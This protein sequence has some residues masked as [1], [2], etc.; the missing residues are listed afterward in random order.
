[1]KN[2]SQKL[3]L[4]LLAVSLTALGSLFV[5]FY[6]K[7][8]DNNKKAEQ[9]LETWAKEEHR[10]EDIKSL[11]RL[12]EKIKDDRQELDTHFA[13]GSDVVPFLDTLEKLAPEAG[14]K[15]EV[16][17]VDT[18]ANNSGLIVGL[19]VSG[20]FEAIYKFLMLLENS[21]YELNFLAM[22][23]HSVTG[24]TSGK[25]VKSSGW[26]AFFKIQLLSFIP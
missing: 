3:K 11:N 18:K 14:A 6:V 19:K 1:M 13:K 21:P 10:R 17:S 25:G 8:T 20:S 12:L 15:A 9:S 2:N 7:I 4:I 22:D 24:G 16:S 26:E 23:I 5:F